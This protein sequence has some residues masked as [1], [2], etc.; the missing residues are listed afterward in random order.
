MKRQIARQIQTLLVLVLLVACGGGEQGTQPQTTGSAAGAAETAATDVPTAILPADD[1][2]AATAPSAPAATMTDTTTTATSDATVVATDVPAAA[3]TAQEPAA[4]ATGG[5]REAGE[6]EFVNPVINQDFPDPDV[7]KVGDTYYAYATN[8]GLVDVQV[9]K[10]TD[11]V[12]WRMLPDAVGAL[13][14]WARPGLT[15]APDVSLAADGTTFVM[16]F[17][18]RD[19]ASD[20]QCIGVATSDNPEGPFKSDTEGPII[21]QPDLGGSID[22][23]TFVDEDG[24]RYVLWKNDGNCC[25]KPTWLYIQ[26]VADDGLTLQGEPTQLIRNDRVWEGP[27]VEAPTLWKHGGKYYLFY[28]ANRYS[29]HTY[30]VGYAVADAVLGPYTKPSRRPLLQTDIKT[31]GA[32]GPGGQ[33]IVLD[34]DGEPWFVY[35]SWNRTVK[36]R[37]V[38]IDE[39]VWEGD[40]PVVKGPDRVPQPVP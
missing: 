38:Q 36:Y 6:G 10:S 39:L 23:S 21:C 29:D 11:L 19:K 9:A 7:L 4:T 22:P 27:L 16:Y 1:T 13:P 18:A 14:G 34:K 24:K 15:W 33:D 12:H 3:T 26:P 28:S 8:T 5:P 31:G 20:K 35:H 37:G 17:T 30:A 2:P 25:G 32:L 40:T